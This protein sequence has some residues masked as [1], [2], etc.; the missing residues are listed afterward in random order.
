VLSD[1]SGLGPR[2]HGYLGKLNHVLRELLLHP[3]SSLRAVALIRSTKQPSA[4]VVLRLA[5]NWLFQ[6]SVTRSRGRGAAL[7]LLDDGLFHALWTI[8]LEARNGPLP[9]VGEALLASVPRPDVVVSLQ[10]DPATVAARL[11]RRGGHESRADHWEAQDLGIFARA[12]SIMTEVEEILASARARTPELQIVR[13]ENG[14]RRDPETTALRL[15]GQIERLAD[16]ARP[17]RR[18]TGE[19][20]SVSGWLE[21]R[22]DPGVEVEPAAWRGLR[23]SGWR[24]SGDDKR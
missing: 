13:V 12:R 15:A 2:L 16:I 10:A 21:P 11:A 7:R 9:R 19:T 8:G 14:P 23:P 22:R 18:N 6:V 20:S 5:M 3:R 4:G 24:H 1:R 17:G